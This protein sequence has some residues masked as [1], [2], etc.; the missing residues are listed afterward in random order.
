MKKIIL[1]FCIAIFSQAFAQQPVF[2][3]GGQRT[4]SAQD[5]P[6]AMTFRIGTNN[7]VLF[8][9]FNMSKG[10]L[11]HLEGF[12]DPRDGFLCS[13]DI[14]IP[15]LPNEVAIYEG[16]IVLNNKMVLFRSV[17]LKL[18]KKSVLFA[19]E[20]NEKGM[21]KDNTGEPIT[22]IPAEKAMNSGD[23]DIKASED[24]KGFVVLA[25]Y[26]TVKETKEKFAVT[27]FDGAL[28]Q[29]W[30][31]ELEL[32]HD[33]KRGPTNDVF[34]ANSGI[35]YVTKKVEGPKNADFYTTYQIA[36]KGAKVKENVIE[37]EAPKKIV[38]YSSV[39][40]QSNNDLIVAGYYTED[41]KVSLGGTGFKGYFTFRVSGTSGDIAS[42]TTNAFDKT[43]SNLVVNKL[44][45]IKGN[46]F[47]LGEEKYENNIATEQKDS[48]GF[49]VYSR[50]F[51]AEN[52]HVSVFD[53][54]GK[55]IINT[56][57]PKGNKSRDDGGFSN[58]YS[59]TVIGEQI[60]IVYNDFQYKQDGKDHKIVGPPLINIKIPVIQFIGADGSTGK[61]FPM[62]DTNIG[63]FNGSA[64]LLPELSAPVSAKEIFIL[65][66]DE[67]HYYPVR[68]KL[69]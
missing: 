30:T 36:D 23:F 4:I 29:V 34:L 16:F 15:H 45:T 10:M 17:F 65:G 19:H 56:I 62:I 57:L 27:V 46:T 2:E 64:S 49:P 66:R 28:K 59:A 42:R 8:Q 33:S 9:K 13:Q 47:I 38:N 48:R 53:G 63:G 52:I 25:E 20:L 6:D 69:P 44:V 41:G 68:M 21:V 31:K 35:V 7:Y 60:M 55:S 26:P 24:G 5:N 14:E 39:I 51:N 1:L 58:S 32:A 11:L 22:S 61:K 50:E 18:E 37:M 43:R 3:I 40:D 67:S 54:S 12:S